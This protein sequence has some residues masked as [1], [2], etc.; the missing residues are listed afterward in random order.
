MQGFYS[1]CWAY[2]S[3]SI[4][5]Y[6]YPSSQ[7]TEIFSPVCVSYG[8]W[9]GKTLWNLSLNP[10]ILKRRTSDCQEC[11]ENEDL[12][13][14]EVWFLK[15][16]SGGS[17]PSSS[18]VQEAPHFLHILCWLKTTAR[19]YFRLCRGSFKT[20]QTWRH[21]ATS[22]R[23]FLNYSYKIVTKQIVWLRG[24]HNIKNCNKGS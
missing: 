17:R 4:Y 10:S 12:S 21:R 22:Q 23:R 16:S 1:V 9:C 14:H 7:H 6:S 2:L 5:F 3:R 19:K 13:R 11:G 15:G 8:L 20:N 24:H 18:C